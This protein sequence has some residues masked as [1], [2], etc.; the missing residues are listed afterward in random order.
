M[1]TRKEVEGQLQAARGE[2]DRLQAELENV[3]LDAQLVEAS[4]RRSLVDLAKQLAREQQARAALEEH[5]RAV[6]QDGG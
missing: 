3:S 2:I 5:L 1:A 6:K 4:L